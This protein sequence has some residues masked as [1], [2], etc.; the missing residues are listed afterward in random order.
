M[1][2]SFKYV[3][4]LILVV[5]AF[6]LGYLYSSY[7]TGSKTD[8]LNSE[9]RVTIEDLED[10]VVSTVIHPQTGTVVSVIKGD[11]ITRLWND[12]LSVPSVGYKTKVIIKKTNDPYNYEHTAFYHG[13]SLD[14]VVSGIQFSPNGKYVSFSVD[15][16]G[17]ESS[18]LFNIDTYR[19]LIRK[20]EYII[21]SP[22][23]W[24]QDSTTAIFKS[25]FNGY[26]G[27]GYEGVVKFDAKTDNFYKI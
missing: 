2:T 11:K 20:D 3:L 17:Y 12:E 21:E 23:E 15:V 13:T 18:Y 22:L 10:R 19:N 16:V 14:P 25:G 26:G 9:S 27:E 7:N 4:F 8:E 1:K 5:S 6:I 24:S